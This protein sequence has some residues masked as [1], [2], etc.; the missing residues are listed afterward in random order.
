MMQYHL[1]NFDPGLFGRVGS[2]RYGQMPT[3]SPIV[4]GL[5]VTYCTARQRCFIW[6]KLRLP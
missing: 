4:V 5:N 2:G 1:A 3:M 6:A